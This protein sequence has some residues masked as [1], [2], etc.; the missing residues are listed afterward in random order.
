MFSFIK[1]KELL[2]VLIGFKSISIFAVSNKKGYPNV[3]TD[4][5]KRIQEF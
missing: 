1:K 4:K 2:Y 5:V 3:D